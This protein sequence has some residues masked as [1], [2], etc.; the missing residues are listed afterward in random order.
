MTDQPTVYRSEITTPSGVEI[1]VEVILPADAEY[2]DQHELAE[3]VAVMAMR[4]VSYVDRAHVP[5]SF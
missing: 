3:A 4:L 5:A 1:R 2:A